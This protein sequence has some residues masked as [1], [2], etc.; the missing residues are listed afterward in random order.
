MKTNIFSFVPLQII[1]ITNN[2][3]IKEHNE[4]IYYHDIIFV[5][6]DVTL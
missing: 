5:Q 4:I 6:L 1:N 2:K 3:L